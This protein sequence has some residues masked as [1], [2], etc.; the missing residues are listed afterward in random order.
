M[1]P[2]QKLEHPTFAQT[3]VLIRG[4]SP[5]QRADLDAIKRAHLA[6]RLHYSNDQIH[7]ALRALDHRSRHSSRLAR[8]GTSP[9]TAT[10]PGSRTG[11]S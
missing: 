2:Q 3:Y 8:L 7:R 11:N 4:L 5:D 10:P 6:A 1:A 9:T